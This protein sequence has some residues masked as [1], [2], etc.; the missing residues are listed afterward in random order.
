[1]RTLR[2][3]LVLSLFCLDVMGAAGPAL[4]LDYP[5]KPITVIGCYPAGGDSDMIARLWAQFAEQKLGQP[6]LVVNKVG[7]GGITGTA[8][9]AA[10][11]PDGYTLDLAQA[12]P[13]M[14]TPN[15]AKTSYSFKSFDYFSRISVGNC[16]LVVKGDAPWNTLTEFL[17]AA[18]AAPGQYS[19]ASPGGATWLSF[20][21]RQL[22]QDAKV[23]IKQVEFQGISLAIPS[24]LGG[25][26]TF[27]FAFPQNYV[28]QAKAGQLKILAIGEKS[29]EFPEAKSFEEQGFPGS[30]Y[31]W[32]GL[33]V[34]K[35]TPEA[36][37]QKLSEVTRE[38]TRD[39]AFIEKALNMGAT[40]SYVDKA[41]WQPMLEQQNTALQSLLESLH[42]Q[43]K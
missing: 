5:N 26:T 28:T 17:A 19:F 9:A 27:T 12:G 10:A 13:V 31:G 43:K 8:F 25:H 39:P 20:A 7:G 30:Y 11:K 41:A 40:P 37:Q 22:I 35:G 38:I 4:A 42:F 24:I 32:A 16:A 2:I 33:A 1:M 3:I 21:M 18:K 15:V 6:V 29:K 23:D 14:L 36:I 34:P